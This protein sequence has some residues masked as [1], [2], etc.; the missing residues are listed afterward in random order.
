MNNPHSHQKMAPQQKQAENQIFYNSLPILG[1]DL[2]LVQQHIAHQQM[3]MQQVQMY[4]QY[5]AQSQEDSPLRREAQ[6]GPSGAAMDDDD[7]D[8]PYPE[9]PY[10]QEFGNEDDYDEQ[11]NW[12]QN[13]QSQQAM[14]EQQE[15]SAFQGYFNA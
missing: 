12:Q 2:M 3:M 4:K 1:N 10:E 15:Y 8:Y 5:N 7:D 13:M 9:Y 14:Q 11:L 6:N